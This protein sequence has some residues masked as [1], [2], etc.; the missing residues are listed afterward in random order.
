ME[1]W[2][3]YEKVITVVQA[4]AEEYADAIIASKVAAVDHGSH[5]DWP[6]NGIVLS[7]STLGG[8][9][10]WDKRV[11]P[12]Y[13]AELSWSA[14]AGL[15]ADERQQRFDK[16]GRYWRRTSAFLERMYG[17]LSE[18]GGPKVARSRLAAMTGAEILTFWA[19]FDGVGPKYAR[20]I[21]M[22]VHHPSFRQGYFAI[23]SRIQK[24][25]PVFGYVGSK[26]YE[27]METF[28]SK[29]ANDTGLDGWDL[30]R[31]LYQRHDDVVA[32]IQH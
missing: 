6:W 22:D 25:L 9:W 29:L 11:Q 24:L 27:S 21:M 16:V 1:V 23:D 31:L 26:R 4:L 32:R 3:T 12:I 7:A 28:L 10:R 14:L 17:R 15:S 19:G 5:P 18:E 30:D 20:N 2:L 13:E 8:S